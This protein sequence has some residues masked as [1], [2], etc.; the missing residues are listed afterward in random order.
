MTDDSAERIVKKLETEKKRAD[1]KRELA[2]QAESQEPQA[3]HTWR[4]L[5]QCVKKRCEDVNAKGGEHYLG[6]RGPKST[7]FDVV[8]NYSS[9]PDTVHVVFNPQV[10]TITYK[11]TGVS[12]WV[13]SVDE[14]LGV[15]RDGMF[16]P[17]VVGKQ[18][19]F[20]Q[21][22]TSVTVEQMRET[23]IRAL[24]AYPDADL[25]TGSENNPAVG[26]GG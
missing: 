16:M 12:T 1:A 3:A 10:C 24:L 26:P 17:E 8:K 23:L 18:F 7:E 22:G 20:T 13:T 9:S 4:E 6:F 14:S 21:D 5:R 2:Q 15:K 25:E 19:F 11:A